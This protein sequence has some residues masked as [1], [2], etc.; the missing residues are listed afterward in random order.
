MADLQTFP[1]S[2]VTVDGDD[3]LGIGQTFSQGMDVPGRRIGDLCPQGT[4]RGNPLTQFGNID[5][6]TTG[7]SGQ[8]QFVPRLAFVA[9]GWQYQPP[10]PAF[11]Q[12]LPANFRKTTERS[13]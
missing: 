9:V 13:K 4:W 8:D 6:G 3:V 5:A 10:L 12:R 7:Q 2:V 11:C 1:Q